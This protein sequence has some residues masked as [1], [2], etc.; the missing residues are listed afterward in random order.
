MRWRRVFGGGVVD[1]CGAGPGC[2]RG[3]GCGLR[4]GFVGGRWLHGL[5]ARKRDPGAPRVVYRTARCGLRVTRSQR[6][7]L[8]GLLRSAGDV[9]CCVLELNRLAAPPPGYAAGR[10]PGVVPGAGRLRPG[11]LRRAG[12]RRG[13]VGA[14]PL[15]RFLVRDRQATQGRRPLGPYPRRRRGLVP[16]RWYSGTFTLDGRSLRLPVARGC[17]PLLVRLDRDVPYPGQVRSVTLGFDAGRL[18]LDVTAEVPVAVYPAGRAPDPGRVAGVD[19]GIIHPYAVAGPGGRGCWSPAGPSGPNAAST[20]V[21]AR[22]GPGP[23]R[24]ALPGPV[25]RGSRR[26]RQHRRSAAAGRRP[27]IADGSGRP[28]TRP[29]KAV[30]AWAVEQPDRDP[31]GRRPA[32]RP[33][34]ACRPP[35]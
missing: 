26:W 30:I 29:P 6:D 7:R 15:L 1:C 10:V 4:P 13:A 35:A 25:Q 34:P 12:Q 14:A 28:A 22:A 16:V 8:F 33:G 23:P 9:W 31:G 19:L 24:P 2:R 27:G 11:D 3:R 18:Y 17:P 21:T 20:C 5:M 32:R